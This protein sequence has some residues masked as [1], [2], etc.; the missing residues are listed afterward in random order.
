MGSV[1]RWSVIAAAVW[2]V[3]GGT[4]VSAQVLGAFRWQFAPYCNTVTLTIQQVGAQFVANG[5]DDMCGA[6][7]HAPATGS[8]HLNPDGTIRLGITVIRDDGIAVQHSAIFTVTS[9]TGTWTDDYGNG[10]TFAFG[11]PSP[12]LGAPRPVTLRGSYAARGTATAGLATSSSVSPISFGRSLGFSA[13]MRFIVQNG[14]PTAQC[15]GTAAAP[16]AAPGYLC[17]YEVS[18][19]NRNNPPEVL[20]SQFGTAGGADRFGALVTVL[21]VGPGSFGSTGTWAVTLP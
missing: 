4:P 11:A 13:T 8:A 17:V 1:C 10:G 21:N 15:P 5:F 19:G 20:N 3:S 2:C 9:P 7:R 12:A 6:T 14:P 18:Q 16:A